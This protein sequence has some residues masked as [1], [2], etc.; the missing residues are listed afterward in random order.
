MIMLAGVAIAFAVLFV[1][2]RWMMPPSFAAFRKTA[3]PPMAFVSTGQTITALQAM[4][5]LVTLKYSTGDVLE[6]NDGKFKGAWIVKGDSLVAVDLRQAK[7]I[8]ADQ[9]RRTVV[10][11]LPKPKAISPRIDHERT[12]TYSFQRSTWLFIP[13]W[14]DQGPLRDRAMKEAQHLVEFACSQEDVVE[15]AR[16]IAVLMIR[17][18]YQMAN[19]TVEIEWVE[20]EAK[21]DESSLR[22]T[23]VNVER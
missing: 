3:D 7:L 15:Q 16:K 14:V 21:L 18:M 1:G 17:T 10:I 19:Y 8:S 6:A 4:G 5:H 22:V 2:I 11:Q 23:S 12:K 20:D 9:E 13:G